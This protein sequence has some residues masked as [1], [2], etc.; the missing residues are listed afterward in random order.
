M[1][2][3]DELM[4]RHLLRAGCPPHRARNLAPATR[5]RLAAAV[6]ERLQDRLTPVQLAELGSLDAASA[7]RWLSVHCPD[8]RVIVAEQLHAVL[9]LPRLR[10]LT[11]HAVTIELP[12]GPLCLRPDGDPIRVPILRR[13]V[14]ALPHVYDEIPVHT[15]ETARPAVLPPLTAGVFLVVARAVAEAHPERGDLLY[16]DELIRDPAGAVVG[17]GALATC[18]PAAFCALSG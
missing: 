6:G 16:P 17:C 10:N 5:R 11:P 13:R 14:G 12:H 7:R 3:D 2:R 15:T 4:L 18:A 9:G 8:Y 1:T